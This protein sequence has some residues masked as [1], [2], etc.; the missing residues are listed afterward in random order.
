LVELLARAA[1]GDQSAFADVVRAHQGMVYGVAYNYLHDSAMAE[2][3]AQEVFLILYRNLGKIESPAHL[4][5]WL[6][7]V[8]SHRCIDFSRRH[9]IE[10]Q[11]LTDEM[12]EPAAVFREPD[13]LLSST[14]RRLV[15]TL[16]EVPRMVVT[17]RYQED[18]EPAE[19]SEVLDMPVNTVK[20][21][22]RRSLNILREKVTRYLG[23]E[24]EV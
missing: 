11:Q 3:L 22:L 9:R 21:H 2:E 24:I 17:L 4:I 18:L 13:P 6:R 20:S 16:P 10:V 8:T 5:F 12:P 1:R 7:K 15:A 23:E 14:L 19:I